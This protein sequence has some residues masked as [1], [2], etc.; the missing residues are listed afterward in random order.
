MTAIKLEDS[1]SNISIEPV[2]P[3]LEASRL[4]A[5]KKKEGTLMDAD[6]WYYK[7]CVLNKKGRKWY[8]SALA[9]YKQAL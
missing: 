6:F 9:C 3:S 4:S 2:K 7:G 1:V 8:E 5:K